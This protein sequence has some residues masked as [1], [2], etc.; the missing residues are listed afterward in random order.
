MPKIDEKKCMACGICV[1]EC[2]SSAIC[3][4]SDLKNKG[5]KGFFIDQ[6]LCIDCGECLRVD[7]PGKAIYE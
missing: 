7:C 4:L 6:D 3:V 2:P 5:Y 1:E